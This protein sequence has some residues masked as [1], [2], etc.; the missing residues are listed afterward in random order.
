MIIKEPKNKNYCAIVVKLDKFIDLPNCDN[1]KGALIFGNQVIV[2]KNVEPGTVG[3]YFPIETALDQTFLGKNNLFRKPEWGNEDPTQKGFF[4]QHGRVRA[5]KFRGHVS[6][7]FWLPISCLASIWIIDYYNIPVGAEFDELDGKP[8]CHKYIP[9]RNPGKLNPQQKKLKKI[10]DKIVDGQFNFHIDT[11]NLRRNY[12]KIEPDMVISVSDKWHGTSAI[13]AHTIVKR[14]LNALERFLKWVGIQVQDTEYGLTWASRKM[15]KGVNGEIRSTAKHF[16]G[17]DIW[18]IV[19]DEIKDKIPKGITVYGEIVGYTPS[20]SPIQKD[21]HYGCQPGQHRFLVYRVTHTN[22]DG[23]VFEFSWLQMKEFCAKM[24]LEFVK[25]LYYGPAKEI[26]SSTLH[27]YEDWS[28]VFLKILSSS[29]V[30]DGMCEHNNNEVPAEG[31]VVRVERLDECE[32]YKLKNFKFLEWETKQLDS[33]E[34]DM[35]TEQSEEVDGT[36]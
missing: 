9:R 10:Q 16:Y 11:S 22:H 19:L 31:V 15:V 17:E 1:V 13:Y 14:D 20:G 23:K 5:V 4:E 32:A 26:S 24:D 27:N 30:F 21:Y 25:E 12:H 18:G 6:E 35:E 3:L 8:I 33:G 29:F 2:G 28:E 7:G 34:V 36:N